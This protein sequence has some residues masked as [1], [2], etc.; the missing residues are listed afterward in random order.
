MFKPD[1]EDIKKKCEK[2]FTLQKNIFDSCRKLKE[3]VKDKKWETVAHQDKK[4]KTSM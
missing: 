3:L 1:E 2:I 4:R